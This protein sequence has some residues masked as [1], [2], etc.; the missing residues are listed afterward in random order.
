MNF[1]ETI[2]SMSLRGKQKQKQICTR[3]HTL[4]CQGGQKLAHSSAPTH[5]VWA[6]PREM[7]KPAVF[8]GSTMR[9]DRGW[10]QTMLWSQCQGHS[11]GYTCSEGG[12]HPDHPLCTQNQQSPLWANTE[13][14]QRG[15]KYKAL[16]VVAG[17]ENSFVWEERK[18]VRKNDKGR[19]QTTL[20]SHLPTL[21]LPKTDP[22][23]LQDGLPFL[24][25]CTPTFY[26]CLSLILPSRFQIKLA[27]FYI[28]LTSPAFPKHNP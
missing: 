3:R 18:G 5:A 19:K 10:T 12:M 4:T 22:R 20:R 27:I 1:I 9:N 21:P 23:V 26:D 13:Q 2:N 24:R 8:M 17:Q 11:L 16:K 28:I 14:G 15:K 7:T 6:E 25:P